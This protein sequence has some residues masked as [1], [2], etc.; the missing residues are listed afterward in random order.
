[1][2]RAIVELIREQGGRV[3]TN[4]TVEQILVDKGRVA[5]VRLVGGQELRCACGVAAS[6]APQALVKLTK[7]HL[8]EAVVEEANNYRYGPGAIHSSC[9]VQ[10]ARLE[11][12]KPA[13]AAGK[14]RV[15]FRKRP[16]FRRGDR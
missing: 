14:Y 9:V 2:I 1:L 5:G 16:G 10:A 3:P 13:G 12:R 8:P 11:K 6:A 4:Q 7:G 15:R